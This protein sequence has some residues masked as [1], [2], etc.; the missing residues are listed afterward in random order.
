MGRELCL[1]LTLDASKVAPRQR[2][3][4]VALAVR[5]A[6]PF[7]DP[8]FDVLWLKDRA[9]VWYWS[10]QRLPSLKGYPAGKVRYRAEALYRG[11]VRVDDGCEMLLYVPADATGNGIGY[12][13]RVWRDGTLASTRWW[14]VSPAPVAWQDY[15]R[16]TGLSPLTPPPEPQRARVLDVPLDAIRGNS[17][18]GALTGQLASQ[19]RYIALALGGLVMGGLLWQFAGVARVAWEVRSVERRIEVIT[20]RLADVVKARERADAAMARI[21]AAMT[22]RPPASQTRLLGE[23]AAIT[24]GEWELS[25]W[26][27]SNPEVLEVTLKTANPDPSAIVATW[28]ASPLFKDVTPASGDRP[29]ELTLKARVSTLEDRNP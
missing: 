13:S 4:F 5:R 6:A 9:A 15:V 14:P 8:D 12:E 1:F 25:T 10:R 20:R 11:S 28:E 24:P 23:V 3:D 16:G 22:L 18:A 27:Q 21:D 2:N 19:G 17:T 26:N 29:G 7:P